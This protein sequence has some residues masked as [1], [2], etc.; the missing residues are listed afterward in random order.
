MKFKPRSGFQI[1]SFFLVSYDYDHQIGNLSKHQS[2]YSRLIQELQKL[3]YSHHSN[4]EEIIQ[5]NL[6]KME[7]FARALEILEKTDDGIDEIQSQIDTEISSIVNRET[8]QVSD[9]SFSETDVKPESQLLLLLENL[10]FQFR[11][12]AKMHQRLLTSVKKS[13]YKA[14]EVWFKIQNIL[15][16]LLRLVFKWHIIAYDL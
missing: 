5:N 14:E 13:N 2:L 6:S 16:L 15:K 1:G 8:T 9:R 10:I 7:Q 4:D 3:I 11:N 12:V